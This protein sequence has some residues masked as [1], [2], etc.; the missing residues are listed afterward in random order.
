MA[1]FSQIVCNGISWKEIRILNC[2]SVLLQ[3]HEYLRKSR[4]LPIPTFISQKTFSFQLSCSQKLPLLLF[5]N[6]FWEKSPEIQ[7]KRKRAYFANSLFFW[8]EL[9]N[10]MKFRFICLLADVQVRVCCTC[11]TMYGNTLWLYFRKT[12][13]WIFRLLIKVIYF[14][15][16]PIFMTSYIYVHRSHGLANF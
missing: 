10:V 14:L 11:E 15:M 6:L 2:V 3:R 1:V 7:A 5:F 16:Y 4:G 8:V 12:S 13:L 9:F